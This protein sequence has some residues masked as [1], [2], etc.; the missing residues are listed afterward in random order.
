[1][2][3]RAYPFLS[4]LLGSYLHQDWCDEFATIEE[5]VRTFVQGE[6]MDTASGAVQDIFALLMDSRFSQDPDWVLRSLGCYY[7]PTSAGI[8]SRAWLVEVQRL[9]QQCLREGESGNRR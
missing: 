9:L 5:A 6:G 2:E 4:H 7:D 3:F 1:M 8:T